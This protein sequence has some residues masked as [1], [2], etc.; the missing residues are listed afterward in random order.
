MTTSAQPARFSTG[1]T[2]RRFWFLVVAMVPVA[3]SPVFIP[4]APTGEFLT[5]S[6]SSPEVLQRGF[7]VHQ[8]KCAKCHNFVHPAGYS[9][10]EL[11]HRIMPEMARKSKLNKADEQAVLAYLL[12]AGKK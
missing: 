1:I 12:A 10:D 4:P 7:A 11:T 6:Q 3:C 9:A 2:P 5:R 8:E